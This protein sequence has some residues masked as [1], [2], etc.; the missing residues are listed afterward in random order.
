MLQNQKLNFIFTAEALIQAIDLYGEEVFSLNTE[1]IFIVEEALTHHPY[2]RKYPIY[3]N[4]ILEIIH[5][6]W[7]D[8]KFLPPWGLPR[9]ELD[10]CAIISKADTIYPDNIIVCIGTIEEL[11]RL[12]RVYSNDE[13]INVKQLADYFK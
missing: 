13:L 3:N 7:L 10:E 11:S 9:P 8:L 4:K 6:H 12:C 1:N 5:K 2:V